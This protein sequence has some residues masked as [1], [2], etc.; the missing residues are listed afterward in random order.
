MRHVVEIAYNK[1]F[2]QLIILVKENLTKATSHQTQRQIRLRNYFGM[3]E[4]P[5]LWTSAEKV[6]FLCHGMAWHC[7]IAILF[8]FYSVDT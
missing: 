7:G 4:C 1:L 6:T 5:L 2:I 3:N 8:Q